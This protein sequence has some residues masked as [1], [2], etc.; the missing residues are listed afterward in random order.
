[1]RGDLVDLGHVSGHVDPA[2]DVPNEVLE[3]QFRVLC[4]ELKHLEPFLLHNFLAFSRDFKGFDHLVEINAVGSH[5]HELSVLFGV[6]LYASV[7]LGTRELLLDVQEL[8]LLDVK[9]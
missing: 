9:N 2:V 4:S 7:R 8:A 1:V 5:D 3:Q 6:E